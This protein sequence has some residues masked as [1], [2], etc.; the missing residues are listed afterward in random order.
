MA[1]RSMTTLDP[2]RTH[3]VI[4]AALV[5]DTTELLAEP[6]REGFEGSVLWIGRVVGE[7]T[8][9]V[10]RA[11]RPEQLAHA[12][13]AGLAVTLTEDGLTALIISLTD[14]EIVLARLHT[15]G[16]DDVNH[17]AVDDANL[18]VAHPGALS[19]VVPFFAATGIHL[20]HCGVHVLAADHKWRRLTAVET[21]E[22]VEIR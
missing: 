3:F 5:A 6:G 16:N 13:A 10:T 18:V 9:H 20:T 15:H 2:N 12:T 22:R 14:G 17:S 11:Y 7:T 8:V 4:P 1:R 21:H 19:V